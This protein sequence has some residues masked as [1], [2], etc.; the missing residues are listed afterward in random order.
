MT[1]KGVWNLQQVRDKY[2]QSLWNN[3][4]QLWT[5]GM[6]S[7]GNLGQNSRTAYSSPVQI[8]GSWSRLGQTK[9]DGP[10]AAVKDDGTLWM[11]G[12]NGQG[13]I[14]DNSTTQ[15]SSP[16]QIPGTTW[17]NYVIT[18]TKSFATKTDGT[19]WV[20]GTGGEGGLAQNNRTSYSS[21][22][23]I[24]GTTWDTG[25]FKIDVTNVGGYAIKTNGTLWSWGYN[26]YGE[27]GTNQPANI[28]Y[29]SPVQVPGTTWRHVTGHNGTAMATKTDGTLWSWGYNQGSLGHN[30]QTKYSSPTQI[31]GTTWYAPFMMWG[32]SAATKTDG[33]LWSWGY[34]MP[35]H[36]GQN[37]RTDYSSPIQVGTDTTWDKDKVRFGGGALG[38]LKTDGA[39]WL[40][41][42]N[43]PAG[44][45]GQNNITRYSSPVQVP[46]TY[47]D[48]GGFGW[49]SISALRNPLTPSQ[50]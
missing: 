15:R 20:W 9:S 47:S 35:G 50:L 8:P 44:Q 12:Y 31:P 42:R 13:Q 39:L 7:N 30:N 18:S 41:G 19:L 10:N 17:S 25:D 37:N 24:P 29:S 4:G 49:Y 43:T 33:T 1:R 32:A 46:G 36:L 27:L 40:V 34:N 48:V 28:K 38:G 2:L 22:V 26:Q 11:M 6:G 16:V 45:L 21:P 23:Q 3:D 5:W 14:G